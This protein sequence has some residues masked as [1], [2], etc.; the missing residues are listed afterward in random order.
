MDIQAVGL[1]EKTQLSDFRGFLCSE[2]VA[3]TRAG[4][5]P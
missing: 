3:M 5:F 4:S 1:L 2:A